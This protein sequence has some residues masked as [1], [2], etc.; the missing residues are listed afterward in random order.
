MKALWGLV[1]A[2]IFGAIA[3]KAGYCEAVVIP[4]LGVVAASIASTVGISG[5]VILTALSLGG[6]VRIIFFL[7]LLAAIIVLFTLF[8]V[9]NIAPDLRADGGPI[10]S[11]LNC[12]DTDS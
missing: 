7:S 11:W 8:Y 6:Q 1:L 9:D 5:A 3:Y 2:A 4:I 12:Q 10:I